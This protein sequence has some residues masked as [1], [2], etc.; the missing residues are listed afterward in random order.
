MAV[1]GGGAVGT[2]FESASTYTARFLGLRKYSLMPITEEKTFHVWQQAGNNVVRGS[3]FE[4]F[5]CRR[6]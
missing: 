4:A 2:L 3:L 5:A 6:F 1:A